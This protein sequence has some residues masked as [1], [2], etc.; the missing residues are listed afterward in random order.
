VQM[1]GGD[2]EAAHATTVEAAELGERF[3]D[4]D[5]MWLARDDQG[6]ALIRLGRVAEGLR[7]VDEVLVAATAG[8]LSPIVTG[9]VYCN[10]IAFCR[11][12]YEL[13][14]AREWTEALSRWCE[15]QP[16]MVAHNGLC[17]VHRAEIMQLRGAWEE[18]L[19]ES[20]LAAERF[21]QG[22]LNE[23]ARGKAHYRQG[24]V[25]R[26]RGELDAAREA[27][28]LRL[29]AAG[30]S[31]REIAA[32]LVISEHTV[33]RHLQNIFARP[34]VSG[35]CSSTRRGMGP[36]L[37]A[38]GRPIRSRTSRGTWTRRSATRATTS[39][40][41]ST[42]SM[43]SRGNCSEFPS[44]RRSA[45]RSRLLGRG[46]SPTGALFVWCL[47]LPERRSRGPARG[48]SV[49]CREALDGPTRPRLQRPLQM[50]QRSTALIGS[51]LHR[52]L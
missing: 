46:A 39:A 45:R 25:H 12:A 48:P 29:V 3:G 5:L 50:C 26:L 35:A 42:P 2:Y 47:R 30:G 41:R 27:E 51:P 16:Q 28:V 40:T 44:R 9:I 18:A 49:T 14:Y 52:E 19:E 24:E 43:R 23:L 1:G 32:E 37:P 15:R 7:L 6:C 21:T 17:L 34:P 36:A 10:T 31:N 38:S 20:R 8:E 13:R 11:D 33:A 4:R 22:A